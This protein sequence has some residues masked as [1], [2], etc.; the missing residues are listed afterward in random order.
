MEGEQGDTETHFAHLSR[1]TDE[2]GLFEHADHDAPRRE[3][4]YCVDDVA[5]A[6][7]VAVQEPEPSP[8]LQQMAG[9]YLSFLERAIEPDGSMHNRMNVAGEWT[10]EPG[11][12]DWWG[13]AIRAFGT[14]AAIAPD[15]DTRRRAL[16]A[17]SLAS[18]RD[19]ND[20]R[21][22]AFASIGASHV[23]VSGSAFTGAFD[24]A[25]RLVDRAVDAVGLTASR[26]TPWPWPEPRLRYA[27]GVLPEMFLRAG[28]AL[29][30]PALVSHGLSL[31]SFLLDVE[32]LD[33]HVSVTSRY[34]RDPGEAGPQFDQQPIEVSSLANACATAFDVTGDAHWID[35][36]RMAW[37][38]FL[39]NNDSGTPMI[40]VAT[41]AGFDGLTPIGRNANRGAESTLAALTVLWQARRLLGASFAL[42]LERAT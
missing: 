23:I 41:G 6:L 28:Q 18:Q 21:S 8:R 32:M 10:D 24:R 11:T 1:L 33:G 14:A 4:G 42:D 16:R 22:M 40:D 35:G 7:I 38:W 13:R 26:E 3:H 19:S 29:D 39:G 30:Q 12:G 15:A 25:R 36:V 31:L 27:N 9:I 17:F 37:E 2:R 5:R 34:G 20:V